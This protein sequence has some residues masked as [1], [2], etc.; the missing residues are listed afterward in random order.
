MLFNQMNIDVVLPNPTLSD[1]IR[2]KL[3]R[4]GSLR[5]D[6]YSFK[7]SKNVHEWLNIPFYE[8][9]QCTTNN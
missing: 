7:N 2:Q 1:T 8:G 6:K 3:G 5:C 9:N 4:R